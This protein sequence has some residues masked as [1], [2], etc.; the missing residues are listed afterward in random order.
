MSNPD[1]IHAHHPEIDAA[2]AHAVIWAS[3]AKNLNLMS[4]CKSRARRRVEKSKML[5][6]PQPS[7][8]PFSTKSWKMPRC[9]RN[10]LPAKEKP[11][12][13]KAASRPKP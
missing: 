12:T 10:T 6:E 5:K 11:T 4:L 8:K 9:S 1:K 3:E 13:S 7:A 2:L